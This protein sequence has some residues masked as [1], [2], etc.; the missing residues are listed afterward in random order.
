M[1]TYIFGIVG[2]LCVVAMGLITRDRGATIITAMA[3][4]L[5]TALLS[6]ADIGNDK[7]SGKK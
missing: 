2:M 7:N 6:I 3:A 5:L 4:F 1:F